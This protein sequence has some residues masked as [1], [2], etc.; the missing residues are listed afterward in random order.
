MPLSFYMREL[1][2]GRIDS[3]V[4]SMHYLIVLLKV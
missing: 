1:L 3:F 2:R 4:A